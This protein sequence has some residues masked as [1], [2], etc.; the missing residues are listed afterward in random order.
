MRL[1]GKHHVK[2]DD[3][4]T[5]AIDRA[6]ENGSLQWILRYGSDAE[7][8]AIRMTLASILGSYDALLWKPQARRN[9]I[10]RDLRKAARLEPGAGEG[11]K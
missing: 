9:A 3:G 11:A 4:T 1:L 6:D 5:W 7:I 10:V 2:L 8:L